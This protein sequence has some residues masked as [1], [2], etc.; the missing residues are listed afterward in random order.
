MVIVY[1]SVFIDWKLFGQNYILWVSTFLHKSID[2]ESYYSMLF[3]ES[4]GNA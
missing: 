3:Q 1:T 4:R 2:L